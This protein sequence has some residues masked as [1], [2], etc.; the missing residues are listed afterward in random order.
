MTTVAV[1]LGFAKLHAAR[2]GHYEIVETGRLPW[3]LAFTGLL[4]LAAYGAGL[5]DQAGRRG[6][7]SA[8]P[9]ALAATT[10]SAAVISVLQMVDGGAHLPRFVVFASA[11]VLTPTYALLALVAHGGR[12]RTEERE[13]V[14]VV[15]EEGEAEAL[16]A[17]LARTS[18]RPAVVVGELTGLD[19][20]HDYPA[21]QP[22]AERVRRTRANVVVLDLD[23]Q[24][25]PDVIAQA[26]E[27]HASGVRVR[28]LEAFYDEWLGKLPHGELERLSLMFDIQEV[29]SR[30][31]GRVKRM[32]DIGAG[33]GALVALSVAIPVVAVANR[34]GGNRGPLF[35]SQPRTGKNGVRFNILKFRTMVPSS[36][37]VG[38]W[39]SDDDP[40][41]TPVGKWLRRTHV[42][43]LPQAIN[44]LRGDISLVGPRPEQPHYVEDLCEKI[45]F[46]ALRH[47]VRPGLTG[48]AQVK[49]P[50]GASEFDAL[51][52]LQF[53]FYYLRHQSVWLDARIAVRTIRGV[54]GR[55]GR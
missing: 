19:A 51:E 23:A 16:I 14:V 39:T 52:K 17:E 43:E 33:L 4:L 37:S 47:T 26:A 48:W 45:P 11:A 10:G 29:H 18:E 36:T 28:T 27:L 49:Y 20:R 3:L 12:H 7:R 44:L 40:R 8:L 9:A 24:A 5:P 15:A 54:L 6:S 25:E 31:Y 30:M 50:Y 38:T 21:A 41:V 2:V 53:E 35:F 22:L 32:M 46:Y 55:T 1:V 42:D 34:F 13:R